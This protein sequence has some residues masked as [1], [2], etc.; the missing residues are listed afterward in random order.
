[1]ETILK[2]KNKLNYYSD[3]TATSN[4]LNNPRNQSTQEQ[5][6]LLKRHVLLLTEQND[7]VL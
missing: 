4:L 1:M 5:I 6:E 3:F 7:E 2:E